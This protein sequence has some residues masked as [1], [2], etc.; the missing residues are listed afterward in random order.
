L[1]KQ[2]FAN[3]L[4]NALKFSRGCRPAIIEVGC[5]P[6]RP[7]FWV[8]DNGVGFDMR[9]ADRL[10]NVFQRLHSASEFEGSGVGLAVVERIIRRHGG[11]V[12]AEARVGRGAA[13]YFE[14]ASRSARRRPQEN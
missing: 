12:W 13:F 3:L 2:V 9:Y 14:L 11:R 5:E 7:V 10:F 1:L 6:G 8:K 4:S